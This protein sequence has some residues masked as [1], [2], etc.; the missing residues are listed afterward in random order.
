MKSVFLLHAPFPDIL[1]YQSGNRKNKCCSFMPLRIWTCPKSV[2]TK[3]RLHKSYVIIIIFFNT[4]TAIFET[5]WI[6]NLTSP[7]CESQRSYI[8]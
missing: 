5:Q 7:F 6:L 1:R 2:N 3:H 8:R 4:I